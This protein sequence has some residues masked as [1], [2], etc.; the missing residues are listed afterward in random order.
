VKVEVVLSPRTISVPSLVCFRQS[1]K[2][3]SQKCTLPLHLSFSRFP[4]NPSVSIVISLLFSISS[5]TGNEF[6]RK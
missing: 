1:L 2:G 4:F 5:L 3:V 6:G